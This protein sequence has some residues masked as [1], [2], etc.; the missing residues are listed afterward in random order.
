MIHA[1]TTKPFQTIQKENYQVKLSKSLVQS[2]SQSLGFGCEH[3]N[4]QVYSLLALSLE[5]FH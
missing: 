4:G 5:V 2:W 1:Y 3:T